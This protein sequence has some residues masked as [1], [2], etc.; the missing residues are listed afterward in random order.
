M[1]QPEVNSGDTAFVLIC[2]ALVLFMTP[3]L[4]YLYAGGSNNRNNI[5]HTIMSSFVAFPIVTI[6]WFIW[7]F[8]LVFSKADNTFIGNLDYAGMHNVFNI[9]TGYEQDPTVPIM[10]FC[11]FQMMF[12]V[13]TP[14]IIF[15]GAAERI[16]MGPFMIILFVWATIVYDP[17]AYWTWN[18]NGWFFKNGGLDTAGGMPVETASGFA[19]LAMALALG[20]RKNKTKGSINTP[21]VSLG[22]AILWFGWIG[23]NA[24]SVGGANARAAN[25]AF[26][27]HLSGSVAAATWMLLDWILHKKCGVLSIVNG[28]V[29]GLVCITPA[30][31]YI[32]PAS[33]LAF[34]VVSAVA[35]FT[36]FRWR[37]RFVDDPFDAF[38][39]H[40]I[41]GF[42][43][44]LLTGVFAEKKVIDVDLSTP[45]LIKGGWIDHN[46]IQLAWQCAGAVSA[47]T[48]SFGMTFIIVK[49]IM[50]IA[51]LA[52]T[53][54]IHED[55]DNTVVGPRNAFL[56]QEEE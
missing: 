29:A 26:V 39:C 54:I 51:K 52:G 43:G 46:Y 35:S 45:S 10:A 47:A 3:G 49:V 11:F 32:Q 7:G 30:C 31:G 40:G 33:A 13:I 17:I 6:Q 21:M 2:G 4:A 55:Q 1:P 44:M 38:A 24:G 23:F 28:A 42:I 36:A 53:S 19:S 56:N 5:M 18:P 37:K 14:A 25:A 41:S 9:K 22:G 16:K 15:S 8:S 34:G 20:P 50:Y 48:Y 12:A 27:T